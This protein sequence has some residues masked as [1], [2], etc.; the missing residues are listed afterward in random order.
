MKPNSSF[1]E[2]QGKTLGKKRFT[3]LH[4]DVSLKERTLVMSKT[5]VY[6]TGSAFVSISIFGYFRSCH[7]RKPFPWSLER[8]VILYWQV[9]LVV[10]I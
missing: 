6:S 5:E 7:K 2:N 8:T 10:E 9:I 1:I 4:S 3:L